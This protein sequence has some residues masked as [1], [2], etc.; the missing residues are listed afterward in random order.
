MQR[1]NL[2][3]RLGR[4]AALHILMCFL[5]VCL[6]VL[7]VLIILCGLSSSRSP[8]WTGGLVAPLGSPSTCSFVFTVHIFYIHLHLSDIL[9]IKFVNCVAVFWTCNI[10]CVSVRPGRGIPPLLLVLRFPRSC[11]SRVERLFF[12]CF[13]FSNMANYS[14]LELR[15]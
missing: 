15:V 2:R 9:S 10:Y 7:C 14:S 8:Q 6:F 1:L 4:T 13:I 3:R 5:F 11:Y 12:F